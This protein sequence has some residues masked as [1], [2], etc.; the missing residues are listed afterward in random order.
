MLRIEAVS[1][2]RCAITPNIEREMSTR[3]YIMSS[4]AS[5]GSGLKPQTSN[6]KFPRK[7]VGSDW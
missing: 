6:L 2:I 1:D 3:H 5:N 7:R 4:R